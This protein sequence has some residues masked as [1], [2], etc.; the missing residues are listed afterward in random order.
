VPWARP[1]AD[2]LSQGRPGF[3]PGSCEMCAGQSGTGTGLRRT[4]WHWDRFVPDT[5]ALGQVCARHSGTGTGLRRIK[6]HWD[7]FVPDTVALGQVCAGHSGTGTGFSPTTSPIRI[8]KAMHH[9]HL[10]L[11]FHA[12]SCQKD[13]RVKPWNLQTRRLSFGH[14]AVTGSSG[15]HCHTA[16]G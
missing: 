4:H 10:Y 14:G 7:R 3:D 1:L 16:T 9:P 12:N 13:E 8:V 11:H 2:C 6:W 15:Q 5:V